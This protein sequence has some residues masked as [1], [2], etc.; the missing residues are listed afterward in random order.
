LS[1]AAVI[2]EAAECGVLVSLKGDRLRVERQWASGPA[3]LTTKWIRMRDVNS[4]N[5][6]KAEPAVCSAS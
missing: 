4:V 3:A 6:G 2:R 1:A 5:F